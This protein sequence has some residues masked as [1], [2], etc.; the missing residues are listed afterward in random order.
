M[1]VRAGG[2]EPLAAYLDKA[3]ARH[4]TA[5]MGNWHPFNRIDP[6]Q[7]QTCVLFLFGSKGGLE[8]EGY[9]HLRAI[10][11][12]FGLR[13]DIT[14]INLARYVAVAPRNVSTSLRYLDFEV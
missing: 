14:M 11:A 10:G 4:N 1:T 6:D 13:S 2:V 9:D 8:S 3:Q 12:E 5:T 7:P